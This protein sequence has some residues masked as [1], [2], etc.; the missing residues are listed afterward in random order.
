[1]RPRAAGGRMRRRRAVLPLTIALD[2]VGARLDRLLVRTGGVLG[3]HARQAAMGCASGVARVGHE[4]RMWRC[5]HRALFF[6]AM[7]HRSHRA[8]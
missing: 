2:E 7:P 3:E 6:A 5:D 1:M 4:L 8:P